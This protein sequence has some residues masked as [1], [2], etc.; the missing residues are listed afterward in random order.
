MV[1][2]LLLRG[3]LSCQLGPVLGAP[4]LVLGDGS[5]VLFVRLVTAGEPTL[6]LGLIGHC[7][8]FR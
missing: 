6:G 4:C 3:R 1:V 7:S 8:S 2:E 5:E